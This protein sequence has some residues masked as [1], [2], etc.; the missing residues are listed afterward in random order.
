MVKQNKKRVMITLRKSILDLVCD[1]KA[2]TGLSLSEVV[3]DLLIKEFLERK[4]K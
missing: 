3:E 1:V 4:R 2:E